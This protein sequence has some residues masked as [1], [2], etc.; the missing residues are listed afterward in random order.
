MIYYYKFN[1]LYKNV[2]DNLK[3]GVYVWKRA[4]MAV[5]VFWVKEWY[6]VLMLAKDN[7]KLEESRR[8]GVSQLFTHLF[9]HSTTLSTYCM[10]PYI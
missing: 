1:I 6:A 10:S 3:L 2:T 4:L 8:E 9:T 5:M 7:F